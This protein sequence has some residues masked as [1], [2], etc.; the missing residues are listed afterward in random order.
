VLR[1]HE[2]WG[3]AALAGAV[4]VKAS[5][6]VL[7]PVVLLGAKRRGLAIAGAAACAVVLALVTF[8]AFGPHLPNDST[9]SRLVVP[10]GLTNVIGIGLGLGGVTTGVRHVLELMLAGGVLAACVAAAYTRRWLVPAAAVSLL[11]I[12]TLTWVMPWYIFWV[13]PLAALVPGR[14]LRIAALVAGVSLL[15]T[16]LPLSQQFAHENLHLYP[17][18]TTVGKQNS[19]YLHHLLH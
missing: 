18:R 17:T 10:F 9:Q 5:A 4:A 11:A 8:A 12:L 6:G 14:T 13:L 3:G 16:W 15:L 1:S 2:Q 7:L 19:A